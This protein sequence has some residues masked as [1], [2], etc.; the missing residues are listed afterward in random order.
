MINNW[1]PQLQ[2]HWLQESA[3]TKDTLELPLMHKEMFQT[4]LL[5]LI[6]TQ[7]NEYGTPLLI[8]L[9]YLCDSIPLTSI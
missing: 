6:H 2:L 4:A 8:I 3:L 7:M 5:N 1:P 9:T